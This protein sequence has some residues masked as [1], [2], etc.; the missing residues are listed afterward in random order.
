MA[1]PIDACVL[2]VLKAEDV[3]PPG[4]IGAYIA[5]HELLLILM[6]FK[7]FIIIYKNLNSIRYL[8]KK[9]KQNLYFKIIFTFFFCFFL[10][11]FH[12]TF[13]TFEPG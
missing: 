5:S 9:K 7:I 2:C 4:V 6:V 3:R 13:F 1:D 12:P 11:K 10:G 8:I